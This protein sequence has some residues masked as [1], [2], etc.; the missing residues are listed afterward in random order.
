MPRIKIPVEKLPPP[1]YLGN[2]YIRFRI[3]TE[4]RNSISEWSKLFKIESKGQIYPLEA[5][6][7]VVTAS[8]VVN[9][10]WDTPSIY[11][12]GPSALGA[13]VLHNHQSEW[14]VHD[15]DIFVKF[16]GSSYNYYGRS[17]DNSFSIVTPPGTSNLQV[18]VQAANHPPTKSDI[19]KIFETT[20]IPVS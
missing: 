4:D 14:K 11:N 2:H 5:Q 13:S 10:I 17:K 6:Y 8:G 3:A 9:L 20:V 15:S 19:F 18:C 7:S 12:V 16:N 1:N